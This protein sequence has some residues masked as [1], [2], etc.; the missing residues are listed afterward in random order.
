MDDDGAD[1]LQEGFGGGLCLNLGSDFPILFLLFLGQLTT[2]LVV[3]NNPDGLFYNSGE[4][5]V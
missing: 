2:K 5:K 4:Q 1:S 3:E